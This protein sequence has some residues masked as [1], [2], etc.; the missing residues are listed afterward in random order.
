MTTGN[1]KAPARRLAESTILRWTFLRGTKTLTCEVR[2]FGK[3]TYNV[4]VV[5][6]WDV[7]SSV[8]ETFK[9]PGVALRRH[10]EIAS[11]FREAGWSTVRTGTC[12]TAG[13]AA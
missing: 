6:H 10:A 1:A 4:C 13:A 5:P 8:V 11:D 7:S 3:Q 2:V 9:R 12:Q